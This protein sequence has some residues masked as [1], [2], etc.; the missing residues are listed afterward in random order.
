MDNTKE[1]KELFSNK[2]VSKILFFN[3]TSKNEIIVLQK[4]LVELGYKNILKKVDGLY[5]NYTAKAIETFFQL[6]KENTDGKKITPKLAK[7]L[8]SEFEKIFS[9]IEAKPLIVEYTNSRFTGKP[10]M[11]H[12]EFASALDRINQYATEAD[13]K[14]LIIDSLR[15]PDKVLSNTVVTPSK[16]SNHLVGHA[17]DM[18]VLH[19]KDYKQLCNSKGLANKTLP[20][21]VGKF[22]SL[23][24]KDTQLRWGGKFK[25]KDTVHIDDYYNKDMAKWNRLFKEIYNQ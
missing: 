8:Y 11:V 23:L 7:K 18:N 24:E 21:P 15:K 17:I 9:S 25:T 1:V 12:Y 13:V 14:L 3:S 19:G 22:I 6:H 10:I 2:N 5:G 20:A 16:V 4:V